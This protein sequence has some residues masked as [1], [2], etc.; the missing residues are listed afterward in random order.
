MKK[1]VNWILFAVILVLAITWGVVGLHIANGD[2][3]AVQTGSYIALVCLIVSLACLLYKWAND[4]CPHCG[5]IRTTR[6]K[7]CLYC[8]KE[9]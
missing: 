8:G 7:Y 1:A 4:K 2:Y 5:K 6:G 9:I 3:D